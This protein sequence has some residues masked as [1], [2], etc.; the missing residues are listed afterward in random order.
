MS[1]SNDIRKKQK[2]RD[3]K[4]Y[5]KE[6][7][8][9]ECACGRSKKPRFSF[10]YQCYIELPDDM[11]KALYRKFMN[12]YEEAYDDAFGWLKEWEWEWA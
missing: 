4:W 5:L 9:N 12:G 8:S 3:T 7:K 2:E 10:C 1:H 6:F 11:Q